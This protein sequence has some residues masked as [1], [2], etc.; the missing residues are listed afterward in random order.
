M[1]DIKIGNTPR[2]E[3]KDSNSDSSDDSGDYEKLKIK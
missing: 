3:L 1:D 2:N